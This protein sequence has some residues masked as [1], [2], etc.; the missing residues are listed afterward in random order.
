[1][2]NFKRESH[3]FSFDKK[4]SNN[5]TEAEAKIATKETSAELVPE[6]TSAELAAKETEAKEATILTQADQAQ[7][8]NV[9]ALL[10]NEPA[11]FDKK[12]IEE[13]VRLI[14]SGIGEDLDREGLRQTPQRVARAFEEVCDG[15]DEKVD[16]LFEVTFDADCHDIV[17]VK[18]IPFYSLCEHHLLPFFGTAHIAYIPGIDGRVCGI[19]KLGRVVEAYAH[20]PQLQERLCNEI[21]TAIERN[22]NPMGVLVVMEA[23]HLCMTMRG[24]KKPGAVT[25]TSAVRGAFNANPATRAEALSLFYNK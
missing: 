3:F 18:D 22:L 10:G 7:V 15:L 13:G 8:S 11:R 19:S 2:N 5:E 20:R 21:A 25:M 12:K 17:I 9:Q 1:M 6:E 16:D 24:V 4:P 14:L 23:E